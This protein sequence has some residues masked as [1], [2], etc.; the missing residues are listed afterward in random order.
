[1]PSPRTKQRPKPSRIQHV[2]NAISS[3]PMTTTS[4]FSFIRSYAGTRRP[5]ISNLPRVFPTSTTGS[6]LTRGTGEGN[7]WRRGRPWTTCRQLGVQQGIS[8]WY[9]KPGRRESQ[10]VGEYIIDH[11]G[12]EIAESLIGDFPRNCPTEHN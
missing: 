1:M 6:V 11:A 3:M 7:G 12:L 9:S 4:G 5:E 8:S 10:I 2:I